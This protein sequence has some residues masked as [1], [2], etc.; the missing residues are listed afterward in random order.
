MQGKE[1]IMNKHKVIVVSGMEYDIFMQANPL[2]FCD[3][4]FQTFYTKI[5]MKQDSMF[6]YSQ[7][8][9]KVEHRYLSADVLAVS[10]E[11]VRPHKHLFVFSSMPGIWGKMLRRELS[12]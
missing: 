11:R 12:L 5:I 7:L 1:R 3:F 2:R 9:S 4:E 10:L 8:Y 6:L